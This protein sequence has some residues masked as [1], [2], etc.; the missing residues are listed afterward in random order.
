MQKNIF[1]K[2]ITIGVFSLLIIL[3]GCKKDE[4]LK[5][6]STVLLSGIPIKLDLDVMLRDGERF[7]FYFTHTNGA[8]RMR[9]ETVIYNIP[10]KVGSYPVNKENIPG[11]PYSPYLYTMDNDLALD[12]YLLLDGEDNNISLTEID[13]NKQIVRGTFRVAFIR[14]TLLSAIKKDIFPDTIRLTEGMFEAPYEKK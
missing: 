3:G 4:I 2:K 6:K 9:L 13:S 7:H 8:G 5:G 12:D 14:D 1:I 11:A 10:A